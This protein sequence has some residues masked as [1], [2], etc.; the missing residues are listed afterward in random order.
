MVRL[1]DLGAYE[2]LY[3]LCSLDH[4]KQF[5]VAADIDGDVL[6]QNVPAAF[7]SLQRRHP[8]LNVEIHD[9]STFGG[10]PG[11]A[12]YLSEAPI[13]V[14]QKPLVDDD[15]WMREAERQMVLR[16]APAPGPLIRATILQ[17]PGRA[18][19]IL[20]FHHAIADGLSAAFV[21]RDL[22]AA[23]AG[24]SIGTLAARPSCDTLT[25]T[26]PEFTRSCDPKQQQRLDPDTLRAIGG[27]ASRQASRAGPPSVTA[28]TLDRGLMRHLRES[29]RL[30]GTTVHGALSAAQAL[31]AQEHK[32]GVP[33][34]IV[35]S[36]DLRQLLGV[37]DESCG[38]Y[39]G[40]SRHVHLASNR[41]TF[42]A[43]ARQ[44][45]DEI[46]LARTIPATSRFM[47]S[48]MA[49]VPASSPSEIAIGMM[50][51]RHRDVM[52]SNLG[53]LPIRQMF[54][55][56]R[57]S[58]FWGPIYHAQ[59]PQWRFLGAATVGCCLRLVETTPA[60]LT[61]LLGSV[62]QWLEVAVTLAG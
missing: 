45:T 31:S 12:F 20:T 61:P 58:T 36:L 2:R 57:L 7:S 21:L 33:Y 43:L 1:R 8:L 35:S 52:I 42:W 41:E 40:V 47:K 14:T 16:I 27:E 9:Q 4:P 39:I 15:D 59:A 44:A 17:R 49:N 38:V 50:A 55:D 32:P 29:A 30:H 54:G 26:H 34:T 23:L 10:R 18:Q 60:E 19:I 5:C 6:P 28:V 22:V 25:V 11:P 56:L 62:R 48:I 51:A 24:Q 46:A 3:Y 37:D 53:R 13:E